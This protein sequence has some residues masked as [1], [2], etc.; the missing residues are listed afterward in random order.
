ME[1]EKEKIVEL[2]KEL[3]QFELRVT[4]KIRFLEN[5]KSSYSAERLRNGRSIKLE[6]WAT[7]NALKLGRHKEATE[8]LRTLKNLGLKIRSIKF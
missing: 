6:I 8:K 1:L 3:E 2:I 4:R 7:L 5:D